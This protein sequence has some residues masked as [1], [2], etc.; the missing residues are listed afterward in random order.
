MKMKMKTRARGRGR[1]PSR[2]KYIRRNYTDLILIGLVIVLSLMS[3]LYFGSAYGFNMTEDLEKESRLLAACMT[4]N[5]ELPACNEIYGGI[6]NG[7]NGTLGD[8]DG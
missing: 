7:L 1:P 2:L 4:F 3:G 8:G 5:L 6:E